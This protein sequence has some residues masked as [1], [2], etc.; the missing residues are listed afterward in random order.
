[1]DDRKR[2]RLKITSSSAKNVS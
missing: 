1:L 2:K